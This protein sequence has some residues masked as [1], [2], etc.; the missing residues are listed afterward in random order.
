MFNALHML[1]LQKYISITDINPCNNCYNRLIS[2][3]PNNSKEESSNWKTIISP[4]IS[5][6][7]FKFGKISIATK[8]IKTI[9]CWEKD[10]QT[11]Q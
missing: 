3:H 8:K 4:M 2:F 1:F 5:E 10:M 9:N 7:R 6:F 11:N